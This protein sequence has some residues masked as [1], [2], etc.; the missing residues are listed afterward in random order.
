MP[1]IYRVMLFRR[2]RKER[3][4]HRGADKIFITAART[5]KN[6]F[7]CKSLKWV[8]TIICKG[9]SMSVNSLRYHLAKQKLQG[10]LM[11]IRVQSKT[12]TSAETWKAQ[13]GWRKM[14]KTVSFYLKNSAFLEV[15]QL[16][17]RKLLKLKYQLNK[18]WQILRSPKIQISCHQDSAISIKLATRRILLLNLHLR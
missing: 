1:S 9:S 8:L 12:V 3:L 10:H 18:T 15:K 13:S 7:K 16:S 14:I 17:L 11:E 6:C 5:Q 2:C 4:K